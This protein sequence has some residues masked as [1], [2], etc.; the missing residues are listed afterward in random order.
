MKIF[1]SLHRPI[2]FSAVLS[3]YAFRS[4][5]RNLAMGVVRG[6]PRGPRNSINKAA[7]MVHK[8]RPLRKAIAMGV[9]YGHGQGKGND[10]G[11]GDSASPGQSVKCPLVPYS[12]R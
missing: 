2:I 8:P 4:L 9:A 6:V 12:P 7:R 11:V 5:P 3:A 10:E 1:P